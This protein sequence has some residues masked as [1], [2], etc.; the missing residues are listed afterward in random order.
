M[1]KTIVSVLLIFIMTGLIIG[2]L[3]LFGKKDQRPGPT[4]VPSGTPVGYVPNVGGE[5]W[6]FTGKATITVPAI[7]KSSATAT[8]RLPF[9]YLQQLVQYSA[10]NVSV[11]S[12]TY[13]T[14]QTGYE[15][16][17]SIQK[18]IKD[19]HRYYSGLLNS[20]EGWKLLYGAHAQ[21]FSIFEAENQYHKIQI[22]QANENQDGE[23][24]QA[25]IHVINL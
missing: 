21:Y 9:D 6:F 24:V 22:L 1:K 23:S 17:F 18:P 2:A 8:D 4:P 13:Q 3:L 19:A 5:R 7:T 16:T 11:K 20:N 12:V 14:G 10:T 15:I 25:V